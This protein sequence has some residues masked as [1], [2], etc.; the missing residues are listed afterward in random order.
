MINKSLLIKL[1]QSLGANE[2]QASRSTEQLL[3]RA[4][5]IANEHNISQ[6][7]ALE[8]LVKKIV[9]EHSSPSTPDNKRDR[10]E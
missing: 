7:E 10:K 3:K 8:R 1:F 4:D 9:G 6:D 5:Q 2:Q